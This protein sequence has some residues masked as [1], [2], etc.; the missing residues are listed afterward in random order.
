MDPNIPARAP[1]DYILK[2]NNMLLQKKTVYMLGMWRPD[3]YLFFKKSR[4]GVIL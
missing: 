2:K 1:T 4:F 3:I